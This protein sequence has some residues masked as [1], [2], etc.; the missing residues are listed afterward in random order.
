MECPNCKLIN[1]PTA[2]RCDC[3][4]DF[5]SG[6]IKQP[7]LPSREPK[8]KIAGGASYRWGKFQGWCLVVCGV[9]LIAM[10][11]TILIAPDNHF[12]Q[13][14]LSGAG[15][16]KNLATDVKSGNYAGI[17][18]MYMA[19]LL[20]TIGTGLAI[21][22]KRGVTFV[23]VALLAM[24]SLGALAVGTLAPLIIWIISF[25]YYYKRRAEFRWP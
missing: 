22:N 14:F 2:Q 19:W 24:R 4:Y 25:Y 17:V 15:V 6:Q 16:A 1:P 3:G 13:R 21:L 8:I 12:G 20:M 5:P 18:G 11:T 9:A 23:L 7:Y 10:M